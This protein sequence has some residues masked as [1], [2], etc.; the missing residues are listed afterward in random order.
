MSCSAALGYASVTAAC[1][2]P[3]ASLQARRIER[4]DR[5]A[6]LSGL[7]KSQRRPVRPSATQRRTHAQPNAFDGVRGSPTIDDRIGGGAIARTL[8]SDLVFQDQTQS[9]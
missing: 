9:D 7:G 3:H 8:R 4:T 6:A 2:A 5:R 1:E